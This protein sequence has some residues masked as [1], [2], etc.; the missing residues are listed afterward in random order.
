MT[1]TE[2]ILQLFEPG[3]WVKVQEMNKIA[4]R[5]GAIL[6]NLR[7][8]GYVFQKR[9]QNFLHKANL[10]EWRLIA[11]PGETVSEARPK[12]TGLKP[13]IILDEEVNVTLE[14]EQAALDH[15]RKIIQER[16]L[17]VK[18]KHG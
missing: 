7:K 17:S 10:E 13:L 4:F 5:Y 14:Q 2:R 3:G 1:Q 6:F 8:N 9:K 16:L 11:K 15:Q 18:E 12:I